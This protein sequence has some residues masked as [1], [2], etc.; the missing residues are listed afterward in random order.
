[1]VRRE[2]ACDRPQKETHK[3]L[4]ISVGQDRSSAPRTENSDLNA[5]SN[6]DK[7]EKEKSPLVREDR[8]V[9]ESILSLFV[10]FLF[11]LSILNLFYRRKKGE[12][13]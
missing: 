1:M 11:F 7:P 5:S 6:R 13:R 12:P 4:R 10:R 9:S 2:P 3:N 8:S